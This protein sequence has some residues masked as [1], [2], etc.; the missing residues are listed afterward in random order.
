MPTDLSTVDAENEQKA[1]LERK[2]KL[3]EVEKEAE[4]A[5]KSLLEKH[6]ELVEAE[7]GTVT[8]SY[9]LSILLCKFNYKSC[10]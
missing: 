9:K 8:T 3:K 10:V 2:R 7:I 5:K 6:N 4:E 1:L